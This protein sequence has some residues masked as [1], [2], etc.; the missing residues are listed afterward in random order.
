MTRRLLA[1]RR[2]LALLAGVLALAVAVTVAL[3]W[4]GRSDRPAARP[5]SV[6]PSA[7]P[8]SVYLTAV[9]A[10]HAQGLR[11]WIET[12]LVKRWLA[13]P[14]SFRDAVTTVAGLASRPGVQGFKIAD[15]LGY[16][17]GLDT[18][19]KIR[20]FLDASAK[21]LRAASPGRQILVDMI[22]PEMGCLPGRLPPLRWATICAARQ[23]GQYPQLSLDSV[24]SYLHSGDIDVLDLSTGLQP[25]VTYAG[26]GVDTDTAQV[27]AWQEAHR[28]GWDGLLKLQSRRA[29]AHAGAYQGGAAVAAQA[30]HTNIDIPRAQGALA[31]DVWTWRQLYQGEIYRLMDPGLRANP[32]WDELRRRHATGVRM[33]THLSP[34]SLEAGLQTD[35][36]VLAQVFSDV[37]VAAGTG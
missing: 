17:D 25:D 23:R 3:T 10:A 35:L 2:L 32:L 13:G 4:P 5:A 33:F 16:R 8:P 7:V 19:A 26:W 22:V 34:R 21:A 30:V 18:P 12:D 31:T 9:D 14:D 15:E 37:F 24:D 6:H 27:A 1:K 36:S 28:R 20:A 11:V 29:L